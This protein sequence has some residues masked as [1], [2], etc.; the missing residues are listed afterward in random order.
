MFG[1]VRKTGAEERTCIQPVAHASKQSESVLLVSSGVLKSDKSQELAKG[2]RAILRIVNESDAM[3][4]ST[5][6][7][8]V[9]VAGL[10]QEIDEELR[11]L[12]D[13]STEN[14]RRI[15]RGVFQA[16]RER[17][18]TRGERVGDVAARA[19]RV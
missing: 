19:S 12:D 3:T 8:L 17:R 10:A 11:G 5:E 16:A 14:L 9:G 18:A 15:R 4:S 1:H 7:N 6:P 2:H 13:R